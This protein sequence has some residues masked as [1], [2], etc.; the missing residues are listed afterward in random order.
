MKKQR[1]LAI[2]DSL[3]EGKMGWSWTNFI[4]RKRF[5]GYALKN[6][7]VQGRSVSDNISDVEHFF[8]TE[9]FRNYTAA[10]VM[11]GTIDLAIPYG[12]NHLPDY[13]E[14]VAKGWFHYAKD[15]DEF[16]AS[17]RKLLETVMTH[18]D[19]DHIV[20]CTIPP[21]EFD[22]D[23]PYA[24]RHE[25]NKALRELCKE[26][27][28]TH[29]INVGELTSIKPTKGVYNQFEWDYVK[30]YKTEAFFMFHFPFTKDIYGFTRHLNLTVDSI[31]MQSF[32]ARK[33]ARAIDKEIETM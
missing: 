9:A 21:F 23:G 6:I 31:H 12:I 29:V 11:T 5:G 26:L 25:Y 18:F 16:I 32:Y 19:K 2:G 24:Q 22:T 8:A 28:I 3:T 15:K 27:G 17:Y 14:K 13:G 1:I 7:A 4:T 10:V 33:L 30:N 20:V